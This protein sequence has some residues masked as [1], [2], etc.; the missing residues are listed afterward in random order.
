MGK[1]GKSREWL[2]GLSWGRRN[3]VYQ[4]ILQADSLALHLPPSP[5]TMPPMN[6]LRGSVA[7]CLALLVGCVADDQFTPSQAVPL[8]RKDGEQFHGR[9]LEIAGSYQTFEKYDKAM[10]LTP[11]ICAPVSAR[12]LGQVIDAN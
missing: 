3:R 12:S 4:P 2:D 9:L 11:V 8:V 1:L 7:V 6:A 10:R 5:R